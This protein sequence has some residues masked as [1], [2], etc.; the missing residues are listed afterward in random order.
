MHVHIIHGPRLFTM[1]R[2]NKPWS[3]S[4]NFT[5]AGRYSLIIKPGI[6]AKQDYALSKLNQSRLLLL[7]EED[8]DSI[9]KQHLLAACCVWLELKAFKG[10]LWERENIRYLHNFNLRR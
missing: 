8:G 6:S 2:E 5:K 3:E 4:S 10:T 7:K 9:W 1:C